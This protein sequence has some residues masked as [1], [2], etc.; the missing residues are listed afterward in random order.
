MKAEALKFLSLLVFSFTLCSFG[1]LQKAHSQGVAGVD[2]YANELIENVQVRISNPSEDAGLN[3][4]VEDGVRTTLALFP[5]QRFSQQQLE[6]RLAQTR[7]IRDVG[8]VQ[9]DVSFGRRGGLD[10]AVQVTLGDTAEAEGRG[11][12]S[13]GKF[14]TIYEKDGTYLRFKLD[15]LGLYYANNNAWYGRPDLML[16]GNP[17]VEG[18][19][20]GEGYDDWFEAYV[21]YGIYGITPLS[22]SLYVYGGLSAITAGSIGQELFT[23]ETRSFTG[24]EDAYVGLV[25]G[26]NIR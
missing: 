16:N 19:P 10:I 11:M 14:P 18:E 17:L 9:Y 3:A 26:A 25:G 8:S 23:D 12:A 5:G 4:R 2:P 22:D 20:A 6:L 15:V 13:G 1:S 7:R 24:I 21:H